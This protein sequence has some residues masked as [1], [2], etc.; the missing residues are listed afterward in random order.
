MALQTPAPVDYAKATT[1]ADALAKLAEHGEEP[2]S[3]PAGTA[4]CR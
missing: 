4:S 2:A 1:V 3:S